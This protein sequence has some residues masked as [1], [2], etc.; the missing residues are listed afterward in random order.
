V[1]S[2]AGWDA[3]GDWFDPLAQQWIDENWPTA[4]TCY[5]PDLMEY[6]PGY[7]CGRC[8]KN[9]QRSKGDAA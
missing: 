3:R 5:S 9:E 2:G 4:C 7:P 1:S 6:G 8:E